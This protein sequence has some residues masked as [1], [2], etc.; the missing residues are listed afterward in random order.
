MV[1]PFF[2]SCDVEITCAFP[3]CEMAAGM[4]DG[5]D[6]GKSGRR[7]GST[8]K[9]DDLADRLRRLD[10]RLDSKQEARVERA[11]ARS[12]GSAFGVAMRLSTE[13]VSAILIGAAI[14]WGI[15]KVL[16]IAPW[17][18]IV[19]LM[20]GFCA[21]VLNVM[22]AAGRISDPYAKQG[23]EAPGIKT[24]EEERTARKEDR[25]GE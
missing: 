24:G 3:S 25:I 10:E 2:G 1:R 23:A 6:S 19:F 7:S 21:G 14:G 9:K 22:R 11:R 12:D 8:A 13:F 16:G 17:G 4:S 20:L 15:D 18:M 5:R